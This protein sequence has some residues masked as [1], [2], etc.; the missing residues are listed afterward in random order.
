M[1]VKLTRLHDDAR[2]SVQ[3]QFAEL[4]ILAQALPSMLKV[5]VGKE[6]RINMLAE[7]F[8]QLTHN[9]LLGDL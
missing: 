8:A 7:E 5:E 3:I 6:A 9:L 4:G 1:S 2:V